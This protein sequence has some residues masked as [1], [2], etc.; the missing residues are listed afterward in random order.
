M[1]YN[2][3]IMEEK[4]DERAQN[5]S[6]S[7]SNNSNNDTET[8]N[9]NVKLIS[10]LSNNNILTEFI[11]KLFAK[12]AEPDS[13]QEDD[14]GDDDYDNNTQYI[15]NPNKAKPSRMAVFLENQ[16]YTWAKEGRTIIT[17]D[18]ISF[19]HKDKKILKTLLLSSIPED[20]RKDVSY[21]YILYSIGS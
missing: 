2:N 13:K 16:K 21:F 10:Q 12:K 14:F 17:K 19:S 18:T 6:N 8:N 9:N 11:D 15:P 3:Y 5:S 20:L 4:N 1:K 7:N